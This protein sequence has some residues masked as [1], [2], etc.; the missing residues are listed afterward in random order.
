MNVN[1]M[2]KGLFFVINSALRICSSR[3][4]DYEQSLDNFKNKDTT[5]LTSEDMRSST[6]LL[7][8][9]HQKLQVAQSDLQEINRDE[10]LLK[11]PLTKAPTLPSLIKLI[12]PYYQLW[13]VAYKF[14]LN[15]D[16]WFHG[17]P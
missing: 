1:P 7:Q 10:E 2:L 11:W 15:Y 14:H 8:D 5:T 6:V 4:I 3:L 16:V 9:L 13:H 17:R 12:E